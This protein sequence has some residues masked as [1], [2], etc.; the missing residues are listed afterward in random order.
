LNVLHAFRYCERY[1]VNPDTYISQIIFC[2]EDLRNRQVE[3]SKQVIIQCH[4]T[5]LSGS[6]DGLD[7]VDR[8]RTGGDAETTHP[9][10]DGPAGDEDD[11]VA[12]VTES[13]D[14]L[15]EAGEKGEADLKGFAV[16]DAG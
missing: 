1:P 6:R 8:K 2:E 13:N 11:L 3:L 5:P 14:C 9:D 10:G 16:D 15:D 4:Q 7:S 12:Q